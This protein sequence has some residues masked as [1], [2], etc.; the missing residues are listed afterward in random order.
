M[1][2]EEKKELEEETKTLSC[3]HSPFSQHDPHS[4]SKTGSDA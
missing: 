3:H 4:D 1:Q 2:K